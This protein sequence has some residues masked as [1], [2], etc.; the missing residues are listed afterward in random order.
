MR[1]LWAAALGLSLAAAAAAE[2]VQ[3]RPATPRAT[4]HPATPALGVTLGRPTTEAVMPATAVPSVG[5]GRPQMADPGVV[6]TSYQTPTRLSPVVRS[7]SPE[8]MPRL[9]AQPSWGDGPVVSTPV[10]GRP[11]MSSAPVNGRLANST[12]PAPSPMLTSG[13]VR[14]QPGDGSITPFTGD[15][16]ACCDVDAPCCDLD[17]VCCDGTC[18]GSGTCLYGSAEYLL[19]QIRNGPL[20]VPLATTGPANIA[21]VAPGVFAPVQT[22][23]IGV[24]GTTVLLGGA[25]QDVDYGTFSGGRFTLGWWCDPCQQ[26]GIEGSFFWL[27]RKSRNFAFTSDQYPVLA[28]PFFAQNPN[29]NQEFSEITTF[30]A[31]PPNFAGLSTGT[32]VVSSSSQLW[33]AEANVRRNICCG[34]WGRWDVLGGFRYMDLNEKLGILESIQAF[35]TS[36]QL[37]GNR[38]YVADQFNTRNQFYGAQIGT[39]LE[40][41]HNNWFLDLRGKV[42]LGSVHETIRINGNQKIIT[43]GGATQQ[44]VGGLLALPSNIG[45]HQQDKFGVLPEV[46]INVGYAFSE[47]CR[48]F[49]GYTLLYLN[50][51]VRPGD[52][53]DRVLDVTQIPNFPV[54]P[55]PAP[56]NGQRRPLVPFRESEFWAQGLNFGFELRY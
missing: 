50:R 37:P 7:Q 16:A 33:G 55:P 47:N 44:Y 26:W 27:G 17:G 28:R 6:Q 13:P 41:K 54:S 12:S 35:P 19:W 9:V 20:P 39:E 5:L 10:N 51:A 22:G 24:P 2:P 49:A 4:D 32:L 31:V 46:G 48:I 15:S 30:P 14:S 53:I 56:V 3:W 11:I 38:I 43:P 25:G 40:L 21:Q 29:L 1:S 42:A 23:F 36:P 18:C 45:Q 52:Q 34:C 8:P